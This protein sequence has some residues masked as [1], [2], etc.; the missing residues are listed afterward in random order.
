MSTKE[1]N[2]AIGP[3]AVVLLTS[4]V[5]SFIERYPDMRAPHISINDYSGDRIRFYVWGSGA[6]NDYTGS[7]EEKKRQTI[8]AEF[9]LIMDHFAEEYGDLN[10]EANDPTSGEGNDKSYF[11]LTA[12]IN[13]V[14]VE[15]LS[16]RSDVGEAIGETERVAEVVETEDGY[17]K[18]ERTKVTMWKPN[19]VLNNY[20]SNGHALSVGRLSKELEA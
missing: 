12:D 4:V 3:R 1:A 10:W 18:V 20:A 2:R 8:E 11:I 16:T 5:A 9:N 15:I 14:N 7:Y 13:G 19:L 6:T 17:I